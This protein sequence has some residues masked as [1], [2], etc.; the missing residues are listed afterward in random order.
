MFRP[1]FDTL[2]E[3]EELPA[4]LWAAFGVPEALCVDNDGRFLNAFPV[5]GRLSLRTSSGL[6]REEEE[7]SAS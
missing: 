4:D 6:R 2:C 5:E 7:V 3:F 1:Y